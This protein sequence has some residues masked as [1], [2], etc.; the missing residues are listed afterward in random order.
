MKHAL[1]VVMALAFV[2][3]KRTPTTTYTA[4]CDKRGA[5]RP[6]KTF[7]APGC[8]GV[9]FHAVQTVTVEQCENVARRWRAVSQLTVDECARSRVAVREW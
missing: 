1:L 5:S 9:S 3:C 2:T 6:L 7:G 8:I 4:E